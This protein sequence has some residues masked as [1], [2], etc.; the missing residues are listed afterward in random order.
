MPPKNMVGARN[1]NSPTKK[2]KK[3]ALRVP[4][5]TYSRPKETLVFTGGYVFNYRAD[6]SITNYE[7]NK[8]QKQR[9]KH[10]NSKWPR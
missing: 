8:G 2:K 7:R 4:V 9:I 3:H 1:P 10:T 6:T 5:S